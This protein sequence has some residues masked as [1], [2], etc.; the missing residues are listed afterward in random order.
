MAY[1]EGFDGFDC[2]LHVALLG[3]EGAG[4][5]TIT[6]AASTTTAALIVQVMTG[7]MRA[8]GEVF[9]EGNGVGILADTVIIAGSTETTFR[10]PG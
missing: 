3:D 6:T 8:L 9:M 1:W 2:T 7:D 4:G 5:A 10:S